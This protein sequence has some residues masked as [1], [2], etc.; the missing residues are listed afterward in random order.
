MVAVTAGV[1]E[2]EPVEG[3]RCRPHG[4]LSGWF[5]FAAS[6]SGDS[7]VDDFQVVHPSHL[8]EDR[9]DL[10]VFLA[11]PVGWRFDTRPSAYVRFDPVVARGGEGD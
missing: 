1:V 7:D 2:G 11:L 9:P 6:Y 5:L 10:A 8:F 4:H 3:V